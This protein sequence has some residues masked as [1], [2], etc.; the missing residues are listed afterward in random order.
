MPVNNPTGP[1]LL[2]KLKSLLARVFG[3]S[4]S[5]SG[6]VVSV[7]VLAP[8]GTASAPGL[9]FSAFPNYGVFPASGLLK[10]SVA[11]AECAA[12]Q[13]GGYAGVFY[14]PTY[15]L[16]NGDT[17]FQRVAV[18]VIVVNNG[19]STK[20]WLQNSAGRARN[21]AD[22]TNATA[23]MA[24]LSDLTITLI[25]GRKYTG[26]AVVKCKNS[27]AAEGI[28]FDFNGG[29]AT[30]T[31]FWA[32]AGILASSG[33][34][35]IGAPISASLAGAMTFTTIT[36]ETCILIEFSIVCNAAGTFIPRFAEATTVS[37]TATVEL[38]SYLW[39]EDMP[40]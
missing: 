18:N 2:G 35:V 26:R 39:I 32:A 15:L 7:P 27:V 31:A 33:T 1:G 22:V 10:F 24:N 5:S 34:D 3:L 20:A 36:G 21:T 17:G 19:G 11:G 25:A 38:G 12:L 14:L 37:G 28:Q 9:S 4:P 13:S 6:L 16:L 8:T 23:T 29:T 40:N 30:A